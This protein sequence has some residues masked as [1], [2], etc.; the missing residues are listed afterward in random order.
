MH[1]ETIKTIKTPKYLVTFE[2]VDFCAGS[3]WLQ[4]L[5][6]GTDTHEAGVTIRNPNYE[7]G[8]YKYYIGQTTP[9]ELAKEY[10]K[11][12]IENPSKAAY[13]NLQKELEHYV[14]AS[15]CALRCTIG[16]RETGLELAS[17]YGI[18]SDFSYVYYDG[19]QDF[20]NKLVK[21]YPLSE[22]LAEAIKEVRTTLKA[23]I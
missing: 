10:A 7:R 1:T 3:P 11:Q 2:V 14:H 15:D 8:D 23:L 22:L 9:A 12:G 13:D 18:S 19:Y 16:H 4:D 6:Q 21:D 5:Y 20:A 17:C